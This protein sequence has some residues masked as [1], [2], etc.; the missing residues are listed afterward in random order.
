[1]RDLGRGL[2]S[3]TDPSGGKRTASCPRSQLAWCGL[4][5]EYLS[6]MA[7]SALALL[8]NPAGLLAS[9]PGFARVSPLP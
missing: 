3:T 6:E 2:L 5:V 8:E 1:M 7:F 9:A 4:F